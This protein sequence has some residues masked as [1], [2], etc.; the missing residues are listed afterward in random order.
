[1]DPVPQHCVNASTGI[2]GQDLLCLKSLKSSE[3]KAKEQNST[4][5]KPLLS[6]LKK[7]FVR[8]EKWF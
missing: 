8:K 3:Q 5:K 2:S 7:N 4:I 6:E 1:M